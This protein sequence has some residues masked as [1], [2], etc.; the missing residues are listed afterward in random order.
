MD[1]E[2]KT[3][4]LEHQDSIKLNYLLLIDSY[5]GQLSKSDDDGNKYVW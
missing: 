2:A 4:S 3:L 1:F 5:C